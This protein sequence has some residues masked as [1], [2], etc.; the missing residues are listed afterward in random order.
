MGGQPNDAVMSGAGGRA[1]RTHA[2]APHAHRT[3]KAGGRSGASPISHL[4]ACRTKEI[5]IATGLT[6][7]GERR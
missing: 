3:A 2:H 5:N 6:Q 7:G 4:A 1:L